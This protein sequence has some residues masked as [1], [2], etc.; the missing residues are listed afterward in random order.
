MKILTFKKFNESWWNNI[1]NFLGFSSEPR[2]EYS[3]ELKNYGLSLQP[4]TDKQSMSVKH[5]GRIVAEIKIND[6]LSTRF[7]VWDL[8]VYLYETE[9]PKSKKY[10]KPEEVFTGQTEQP[11]GR[12]SKKGFRSETDNA[13]KYFIDWWEKNTKSG[14]SK[15]PLF[16]IVKTEYEPELKKMGLKFEIS[17][18]KQSATI[19]DKSKILAK[20][21]LNLPEL[22]EE[23]PI[24]KWKLLVYYYKS[25]SLSDE[26][27][28]KKYKKT[29][30][31][32]NQ[33]E[34]PYGQASGVYV[35]SEMAVKE[36]LDF[37]E[38]KTKSGRSRN[39]RYKVKY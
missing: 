22:E 8:Y 10:K 34:Q 13:L 37:Y 20:I 23:R 38:N 39:P 4:S 9:I 18:D 15:N 32:P 14:R 30:E 27:Q 28:T 7:P 36:F 24:Y 6:E 29:E 12:A 5:G 17:S 31:L 2:T 25:E 26:N 21:N 11:Y 19:S 33:V 16:Q 3:E 1:K 35:E